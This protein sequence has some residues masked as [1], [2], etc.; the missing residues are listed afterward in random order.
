MGE[1][2][3]SSIITWKNENGIWIARDPETGTVSAAHTRVASIASLADQMSETDVS[4]RE[5]TTQ[6]EVVVALARVCDAPTIQSPDSL[7]GEYRLRMDEFEIRQEE[8]PT[9]AILVGAAPRRNTA[10]A[11]GTAI[12]EVID[13]DAVVDSVEQELGHPIADVE[14]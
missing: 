11:K 14:A 12:V 4:T 7:E 6:H 9:G 2:F 1:N 8:L 3:P 10:M 13:A 5:N